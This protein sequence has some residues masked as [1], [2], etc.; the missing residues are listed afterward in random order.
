[1]ERN[2]VEDQILTDRE[3]KNLTILELIRRRG[4]LTRTEISKETE[5]NIVTVSN[6]INNYI[7]KGLVLEGGLDVSTG[8]RR[9]VM[10]ELNPK[11]GFVIGVGVD[12]FNEIGLLTDLQANVLVRIK[13]PRPVGTDQDIIDSLVKLVEDLVQKSELDNSKIKGLGIGIPGI[14]DR[15]VGT[16]RWPDQ[17]SSIYISGV[18]NMMEQKFNIPTFLENDAT[19]AAC[20]ERDFE[21]ESGI[22]NLIFMYSGIGCGLIINGQ[23]YHGS[24]G[25]AGELGLDDIT[26]EER[27]RLS[28]LIRWEADLGITSRAKELLAEGKE[29][30]ITELVEGNIDSISMKI[31]I[32]ASRAGDELA[33]DLIRQVGRELGIKIAYLANFLNPE[34]VVIGGGIERAGSVI[35]DEIKK[36]VREKSFEEI[37][38]VLRI[39][40]TQLGEDS[41]ALGAV[42]L[43]IQE[44]FTHVMI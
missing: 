6:Y 5:L 23:I 32:E 37:S 38:D 24:T 40:P 10:V 36:T 43:V 44:I 3:R 30:K 14:V 27:D 9:P 4:P 2:R 20:G 22:N 41:I 39:V 19:V 33:T 11:A 29:S 31:I 34:V 8:G 13:R 16:I 28:G 42:S 21:L 18:K 26:D 1:M 7:E 15:R 17:M 25:C 12:L 35:L